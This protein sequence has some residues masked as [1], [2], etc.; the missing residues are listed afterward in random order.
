MTIN[1]ARPL[2]ILK[3]ADPRLR[4]G[5]RSHQQLVHLR[6]LR[7]VYILSSRVNMHLQAW[8]GAAMP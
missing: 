2:T 1:G 7:V 8:E 4:A 6:V 5:S 3:D